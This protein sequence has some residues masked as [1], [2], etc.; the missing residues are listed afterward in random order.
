MSG[1]VQSEL[2]TK[3]QMLLLLDR[4]ERHA[5]TPR[6]AHLLR[7]GVTHLAAQLASAGGRI[8]K[9]TAELVQARRE[10]DE[11][12]RQVVASSPLVAACPF[13][14]AAVGVAC[15]SMRGLEPPRTPHTARIRA[16][17][18]H[19]FSQGLGEAS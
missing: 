2:P 14:R 10:R 15:R 13:C 7:L 3:E 4:A 19:V 1:E 6:E 11:A 9:L 12:L 18:D 5:L 8:G 17:A 16:A